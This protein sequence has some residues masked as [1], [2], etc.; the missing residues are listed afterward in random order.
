[1]D[2]NIFNQI[3]AVP[4]IVSTLKNEL[5]NMQYNYAFERANTFKNFI[6]HGIGARGTADQYDVILEKLYKNRDIKNIHNILTEEEIYLLG[7]D[8]YIENNYATWYADSS[9]EVV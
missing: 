7:N 6:Y 5:I 1:M 8:N 9:M 4:G 2:F 3:G